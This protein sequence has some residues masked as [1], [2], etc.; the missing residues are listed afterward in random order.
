MCTHIDSLDAL[1]FRIQH[2]FKTI[3]IHLEEGFRGGRRVTRRS[4]CLALAWLWMFPPNL[5]PTV[6]PRRTPLHPSFYWKRLYKGVESFGLPTCV[7]SLIG[8]LLTSR[9]RPW[10]T[11]RLET[12][13]N[14]HF[15]LGFM[16]NPLVSETTQSNCLIWGNLFNARPYIMNRASASAT[17]PS[18]TQVYTRTSIGNIVKNFNVDQDRI[19]TQCARSDVKVHGPPPGFWCMSSV[20]LS[21]SIRDR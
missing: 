8:H 3:H 14:S 10:E 2:I 13:S 5:Q 20:K 9:S 1:E 16:Q 17:S 7:C 12:N 18:S 21:Q 11:D 15:S 4:P 6:P 19:T